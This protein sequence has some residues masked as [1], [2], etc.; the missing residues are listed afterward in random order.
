MDQLQVVTQQRDILL[1]SLREMMQYRPSRIMYTF[2][3]NREIYE[4]RMTRV[5]MHDEVLPMEDRA[6]E[7]IALCRAEEKDVQ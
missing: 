7:A 5:M 3:A 1:R 4:G 2:N 6:R